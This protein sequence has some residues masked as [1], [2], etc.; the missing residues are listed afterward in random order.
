M[1]LLDLSLERSVDN[2][3]IDEA[4]LED[5]E[6]AD[7]REL[8]RLWETP[9]PIV[10]LG[11]SSPINREVNLDYCI[12]HDIE[13][14]RR[15]S[16]GST[17]VTGPGC[18]MYAVVLDYRLRPELRMLEQAHQ[19]VMSRIRQSIA[20]VGVQVDLQGTCDLTIAGR[21]FSGNAL[22]C[23]RNWMMYHGTLL[24]DFDPELIQACLG[25]PMR[26]PDYRAGRS[27]REFL[28]RLPVEISVLRQSLISTWQANCR[29]DSW[30]RELTNELA[31]NKY[32]TRDWTYKI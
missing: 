12:T 26:Q 24:C 3:A 17:V 16:G 1:E 30:P 14:F 6:F 2:I 27:H 31:A 32:S 28:T 19:F 23:K 8:L 13:I 20:D 5:A 15:C 4:L 25:E 22:R 9:V 29:R 10:V 18:L 7:G 21:K 11:R